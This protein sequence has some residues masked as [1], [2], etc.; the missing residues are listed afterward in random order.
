MGGVGQAVVG[1]H[2]D[3]CVSL[4]PFLLISYYNVHD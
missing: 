2:T 1:S 3:N 4:E